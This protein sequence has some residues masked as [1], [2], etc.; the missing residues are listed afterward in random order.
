[1]RS[2]PPVELHLE[3]SW[4]LCWRQDGPSGAKMGQVGTKLAVKFG[5]LRT[6]RR[7]LYM[8]KLPIP[9]KAAT[10]LIGSRRT[11]VKKLRKRRPGDENQNGNVSKVR[12]D[13]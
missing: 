3:A 1:M 10:M 6:K 9:R 12:L 13:S 4:S 11:V 8:Q 7:I 5:K 2:G